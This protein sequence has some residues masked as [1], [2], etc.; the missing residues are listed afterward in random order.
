MS[1]ALELHDSNVAQVLAEGDRLSIKFSEAYVHASEGTPGV[2][3]GDGYLQ[4]AALIFFGASWSGAL[5]KLSGNLSDG[6]VE[7][8]GRGL[9]LIPIPF[10]VSGKVNAELTFVSG[11]Q[12]RISA[13]SVSCSIYGEARWVEAYAG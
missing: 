13:Q 10:N 8:D 4:P 5:S 11:E 7:I 6:I 3:A 1:R 12:L 9:P 2:S